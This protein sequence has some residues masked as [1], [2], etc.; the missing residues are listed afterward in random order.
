MAERAGFEREFMRRGAS[1]AILTKQ[2]AAPK[3]GFPFS[4]VE[5]AF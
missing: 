4:A 2:K 3:S 5:T 1:V